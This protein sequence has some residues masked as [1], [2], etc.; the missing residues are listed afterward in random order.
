MAMKSLLS[1]FVS[2]ILFLSIFSCSASQP[3]VEY[4]YQ[5]LEKVRQDAYT[6]IYKYRYKIADGEWKDIDIYVKNENLTYIINMETYF[7]QMQ[8]R[9]VY[10]SLKRSQNFTSQFNLEP[11]TVN[12][13][14]EAIEL[15]LGIYIQDFKSKEIMNPE[16]GN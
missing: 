2:L 6:E 7:G 12:D 14:Q 5:Y 13:I 8:N 9:F 15:A 4:S 10:N 16:S 1:F 11:E 3:P